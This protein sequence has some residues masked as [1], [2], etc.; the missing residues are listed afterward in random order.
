MREKKYKNKRWYITYKKI[1]SA[2]SWAILTFL[3]I[4]GVALMFV[5]INTKISEKKDQTPLFSLYTIISPS[6]EPTIK[7]WDVVVVK[8][9][10]TKTLKE[11]DVISFYS[12]SDFFGNTPITH[13]IRRIFNEGGSLSFETQGDANATPDLTNVTE[14]KVIGKVIFK[15]PQL[16]R[17]QYFLLSKAGWLIALVIP[18]ITII[19]YDAI[20][21][22]K[23]T[24]IRRKMSELSAQE[25]KKERDEDL[26]MD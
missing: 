10:D 19:V 11:N 25:E 5:L 2:F 9:T 6:M 22:I 15:I 14:D 1:L 12:N 18:A 3:G 21:I 13:R 24:K 16:G 7:V 8:R 20:K 23:L 26:K 4:I 17:I